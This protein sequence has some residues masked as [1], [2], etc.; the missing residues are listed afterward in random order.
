MKPRPTPS[1]ISAFGQVGW[2]VLFYV[3][4]AGVMVLIISGAFTGARANWGAALLGLVLVADLGRANEPWIV[5]WDY[6]EKYASNPIIDK[7]REKPF[8]H[9]VVMFP[10]RTPPESSLLG[11][12]YQNQWLMHQFPYYNIQSLE[13]V[14][15]PRTRWTWRLS[16][17]R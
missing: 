9:R 8:E 14:Q 17:T 12:L 6:K 4:A 7:L 11:Q 10:F 15:M 1:P 13:T 2:F 16:G 5:Y 3:L